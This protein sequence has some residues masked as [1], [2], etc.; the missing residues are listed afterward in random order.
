VKAIYIYKKKKKKKKEQQ[1]L[2]LEPLLLLVRPA[3]PRGKRG[4]TNF[5]FLEGE[6][7]DTADGCSSSE[8]EEETLVFF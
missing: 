7:V 1:K 5:F 4:A 8:E 6:G 2:T 3:A